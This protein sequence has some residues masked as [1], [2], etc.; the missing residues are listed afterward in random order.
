MRKLKFLISSCA[1]LLA[2]AGNVNAEET[3][4]EGYAQPANIFE[5]FNPMTMFSGQTATAPATGNNPMMWMMTPNNWVNPNVWA[6]F[7]Q[8]ATMTMMM[9]P[10]NYMAMMNPASYMHLMNPSAYM[11]FMNPQTYMT[12]MN[13]QSYAAMMNPQT[14][15]AMMNPETYMQMMNSLMAAGH[16]DSAVESDSNAAT[17]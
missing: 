4:S 5:M 2:M 6:Q 17:N 14:Y 11:G 15:T 8:P 1:V 7:M 10:A 3:A 13:P 12:M 9:N 16:A